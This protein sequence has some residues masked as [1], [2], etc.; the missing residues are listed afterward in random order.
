MHR[1]RWLSFLPFG[2]MANT[3][4]YRSLALL[5]SCPLALLPSCPLCPIYPFTLLLSHPVTSL[6]FYPVYPL[7]TLTL[8]PETPLWW[9]PAPQVLSSY[10]PALPPKS[11][12]KFL[13]AS[14]TLL[15]SLY[16]TRKPNGHAPC[17]SAS[18]NSAIVF[19]IPYPLTQITSRPLNR[20]IE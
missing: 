15:K 9:Y 18:Y 20:D 11:S 3:L 8:L 7:T 19:L 12:P 5:L 4:F 13:R 10:G 2:Y 14:T 1:F 16:L 17:K 6:H